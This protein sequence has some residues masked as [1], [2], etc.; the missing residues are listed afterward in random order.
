MPHTK[1]NVLNVPLYNDCM[2]DL[3]SNSINN[4]YSMPNEISNY[5]VSCVRGY[6]YTALAR[7]W[8]I[9]REQKKKQSSEQKPKKDSVK[10]N[11]NKMFDLKKNIITKYTYRN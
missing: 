8:Y 10:A 11:F 4:T 5:S 6:C 1:Y 2:S 7:W 3:Y 9:H